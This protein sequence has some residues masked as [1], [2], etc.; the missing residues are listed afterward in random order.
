MILASRATRSMLLDAPLPWRQPQPAADRYHF[1]DFA[2]DVCRA[3]EALDLSDILVSATAPAPISCSRRNHA[4]SA[5]RARSMMEPTVMDPRADY[6]AGAGLS[7]SRP[8]AVQSVL[9]RQAEF[10][11]AEVAFQRY[12]AAPCVC[13]HGRQYLARACYPCAGFA[14]RERRGAR[15]AARLRSN[16]PSC[17]RP[18]KRMEQSTAATSRGN[19]FR[20]AVRRSI[21]RFGVATAERSW[22]V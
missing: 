21:A 13:R 4:H 17:F 5:F 15:C 1:Q 12:R 6:A 18:A 16:P 10:D 14:P 19:P 22:P 7:D 3:I 11:S 8:A 20:V 2:E 9:R